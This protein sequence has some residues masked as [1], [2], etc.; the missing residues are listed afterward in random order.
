MLFCHTFNKNKSN[1]IYL[2]YLC[3]KIIVIFLFY[4]IE[5]YYVMS[6]MD[7]LSFRY[8]YLLNVDNMKKYLSVVKLIMCLCLFI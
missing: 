2:S 3:C 8:K 7:S 5:S 6:F 1:K 4:N